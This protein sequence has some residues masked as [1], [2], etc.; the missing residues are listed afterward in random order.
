M[1]KKK[2][3][4]STYSLDG[5]DDTQAHYQNWAASYDDEVAENGYVT[6]TRAAQALW[7]LRPDPDLS[8]LDYGC[9]TGLAGV[10]L[11]KVGFRVIDGMDPSPK[12]L[13]GAAEKGIYRS[14][15]GFEI[16]NPNPLKQDAYPVIA[17]IGVI[18]TGAAPP[19]TFDLLMKALPRGGF[20][21]FSL[22][23]HALAVPEFSARL[24]DWLDMGAARLLF[25]E[26]G[27]HLPGRDMNSDVY[28][29][30]KA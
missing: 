5:A 6:P 21:L 26:H 16:S 11:Y 19:D 29:I 27:P 4:D 24:N 25:R 12:M 15:T 10:E 13:D 20:L 2:F 8:I 30:E 1:S 9:G 23:D 28:I 22:N 3:L 7:S 18:G 14:L 17:A